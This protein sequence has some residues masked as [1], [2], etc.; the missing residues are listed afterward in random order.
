VFR[1][2]IHEMSI[3]GRFRNRS[4]P[5]PHRDPMI[6]LP[7]NPRWSLVDVQKVLGHA[8]LVAIVDSLI[9]RSGQPC[10]RVIFDITVG[11]TFGEVHCYG[12]TLFSVRER[13]MGP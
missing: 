12:V 10:P 4:S 3:A 7:A 11:G 9:S 13:P 2:T 6:A 5:H 8:H 1:R